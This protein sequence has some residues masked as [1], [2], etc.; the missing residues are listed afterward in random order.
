M[1]LKHSIK[2]LLIIIVVMGCHATG[3]AKNITD[4]KKYSPEGPSGKLNYQVPKNV[5][6]TDIINGAFV[7]GEREEIYGRLSLP[8]KITGKIP[9]VII[10]HASGGVYSWRELK[11]AKLL[12]KSGIAAFV[13]YSFKA[14]GF[15][16]TKSTME[17]GT[18]FGTRIADALSALNFLST[19]PDI[20]KNRIG[21]M[22]YSSGG[23]ASLLTHDKKVLKQMVEGDLKF[24][25]HLNVFA[26]SILLFKENQPTNSP[27]L[28][29]IGEKDNACPIEKV[30]ANVERLKNAG[31]DIETIVYPKAHHVFDGSSAVRSLTMEND[32]GCQFQILNNGNLLDSASGEEF[33]ER[34]L[35]LD[36]NKHINPC[37]TNKVTW[38]RNNFAS[39]QY[40]KD[41]LE[42]FIKAL[43]P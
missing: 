3:G 21:I 17:T 12:K 15:T 43:K 2:L 37:K 29:L 16:N 1:F 36:G 14:R 20:D 39:K 24:A 18:T 27:M 5:D 19:H 6:L 35:Y 34:E 4:K 41:T 26:G 11:I 13:P 8:K 10:M 31:G 9:A 25:A 22:G 42:F 28:F 7:N 23:F 33:P 38:G 30:L 32:G 40:K